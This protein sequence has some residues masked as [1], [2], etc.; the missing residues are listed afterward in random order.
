LNAILVW[1]RHRFTVSASRAFFWALL[2]NG[3]VE[4]ARENPNDAVEMVDFDDH[5][6]ELVVAE[7]RLQIERQIERFRHATERAQVLLTLDLALLGFMLTM[8]R[9]LHN[10]RHEHFWIALVVFATA[11][12]LAIYAIGLATAVIALPGRFLTV[13]TTQMTGWNPPILRT[14]AADYSRAVRDGEMTADL[15][16]TVFA[17]ATRWTAWTAI[18]AATAFVIINV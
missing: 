7:G 14:L 15:R 4:S 12:D 9:Q 5:S 3:S 6:L 18:V 10:L 17:R 1:G 16:V 13:D 11:S 2:F 8:L